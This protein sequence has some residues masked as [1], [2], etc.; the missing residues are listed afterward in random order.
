MFIQLHAL[1]DNTPIWVNPKHIMLITFDTGT[2]NL[3][4]AGNIGM[5]IVESQAEVRQ[6]VSDLTGYD[7]VTVLQTYVAED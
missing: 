5:Q 2:T 4:L 7:A 6:L 1:K 3:M